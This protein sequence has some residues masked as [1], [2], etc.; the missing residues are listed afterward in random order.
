MRRFAVL[1]VLLLACD[2]APSAAGLPEWTAKDHDHAEE[3]SR[4]IDR[5]SAKQESKDA[6]NASELVELT[7]R[8]QCATCHG[9][10]GRGDG[11]N[12][13]MVQA[14]D[15]TADAFQSRAG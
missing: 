6:G 13:P 15:L 10:G 9:M 1:L 12:G 3:S 4:L 2:R 11:P 7:W 8:N 5:T 14:T